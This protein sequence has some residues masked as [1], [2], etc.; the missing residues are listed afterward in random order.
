MSGRRQSPEFKA[1][2]VKYVHNGDRSV[3]DIARQLDIHPMTLRNWVRKEKE[4]A[5]GVSPVGLPEETPEQEVVRLRQRTKELFADNTRLEL[6]LEFAKK[7]AS[8]LAKNGRG[9]TS[10]RGA[11]G[12]KF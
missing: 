4:L 12:G 7:V 10:H 1:D 6:E 2:A 8:W 3:E 9:G 5:G 11:V